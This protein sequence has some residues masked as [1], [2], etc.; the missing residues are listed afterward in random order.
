MSNKRMQGTR[1]GSISSETEEGVEFVDRQNVTFRTA[2]GEEFVVTFMTG[3]ELPYDWRSP[4]SS[5]IGRRLDA[6]GKPIQGDDPNAPTPAA[7]TVTHWEQLMK[8][9]TIEELEIILHDRIIAMR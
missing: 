5:N 9:R 8:R 2:D 6:K 1:L 3:V 7:P 4:R